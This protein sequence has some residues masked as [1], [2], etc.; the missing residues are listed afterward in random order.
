MN[1]SSLVFFITVILPYVALFIFIN[2][3]LYRILKWVNTPKASGHFSLYSSDGKGNSLLNVFQ[4]I[5]FFPRMIREEKILWSASWLFHF[6]LLLTAFSHYKVFLPYSH[7]IDSFSPGTFDLISNFLDAGASLFMV[8]S[9]IVL[10]GRRLG[11]FMR[12]LS[13]LEDYLVLF[14]ILVI[15][16]TGYMTRY[17]TSVNLL[18]LRRYFASLVNLSPSNIPT[19]PFFL[20]H[21]TFVMILM[22]YFPIGKMTHMIG[23]ILTSRLVRK[24]KK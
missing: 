6:S 12:I 3:L 24:V 11:G 18:S 4:D 10:I 22:I 20:V 21:Y 1:S 7:I 17:S 5:T 8:G 23:S 14:L 2:G 13:E 19:D 9:L 15:A 16:V